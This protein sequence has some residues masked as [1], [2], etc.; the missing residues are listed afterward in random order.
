MITRGEIS[1][2]TLMPSRGVCVNPWLPV[3]GRA[4]PL[5]LFL[6]TPSLNGRGYISC[7][8][9]PKFWKPRSEASSDMARNKPTFLHYREKAGLRA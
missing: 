6:S 5:L 8:E 7:P 3:M 2:T 1:R 4:R 9:Y